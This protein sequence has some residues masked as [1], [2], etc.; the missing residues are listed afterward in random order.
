[1]VTG[2]RN[3]NNLFN[4]AV[5]NR[6]SAK[7]RLAEPASP[8]TSPHNL[9]TYPLMHRLGKRNNRPTHNSSIFKIL[10][11]CVLKLRSQ[12]R[13]T[14]LKQ[15]YSLAV[16]FKLVKR[17]DI[18]PFELP[19][20]RKKNFLFRRATLFLALNQL[21]QLD[22]CFFAF[23]QQK[24]INELSYRFTAITHTSTGNHQWVV[25]IP[26]TAANVQ[27]AKVKHIKNIR[28]TKLVG[29]TKAHDIKTL[30]CRHGLQTKQRYLFL[31]QDFFSINP[32]RKHP[33]SR[34]AFHSVENIIDNRKPHIAHCHFVNIRE[35]QCDCYFT[36][37]EVFFDLANL[38]A[39]IPARLANVRQKIL[40]NPL[41]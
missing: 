37:R 28:V 7:A 13:H 4:T 1:M 18:R 23:A 41:C 6:P 14:R 24:N 3:L 26:K 34:H 10:N 20:D 12:I 17:G 25:F 31:T 11:N 35:A 16:I 36:P 15:L 9:N 39:D 29:Q 40:L 33:L 22:H 5:P 27:S 30:Q 19:G 38:P 8:G 2:L 32:R 21:N